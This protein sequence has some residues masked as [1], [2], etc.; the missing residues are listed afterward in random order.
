M[1][2]EFIKPFERRGKTL[3]IGRV[4][5]CLDEFGLAMIEAG[6]AI[7]VGEKELLIQ[8]RKRSMGVGEESPKNTVSA[9]KTTKKEIK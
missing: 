9:K 6:N 7:E 2:I 1:I 5:D 4:I 3:P 8:Q